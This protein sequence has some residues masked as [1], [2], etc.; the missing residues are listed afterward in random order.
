M[1]IRDTETRMNYIL[2]TGKLDNGYSTY[3][4]LPISSIQESVNISNRFLYLIAGIV[5]IVGGIAII[6]IS[7]QF[8]DPISEISA[9][10]KK[11]AN[12]DFSHKYVVTDDDEINELVEIIN[13][14]SEKLEKT[15][16]QLR[17]SNIELDNDI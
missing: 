1:N 10:A 8:S 9:I 16:N 15:I 17:K 7:K 4:R 12:L 11:I 6:F 14:I 2:L 13:V 5:I 3:I